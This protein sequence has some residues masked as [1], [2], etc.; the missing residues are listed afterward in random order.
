MNTCMHHIVLGKDERLIEGSPVKSPS[1]SSLTDRSRSSF[2]ISLPN[3][4]RKSSIPKND[5]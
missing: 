5:N 1:A 2:L 3:L 4:E